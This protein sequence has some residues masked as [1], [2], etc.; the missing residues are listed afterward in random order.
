MSEDLT[1]ADVAA[2]LDRP[3]RTVRLWCKQGRFAGARSVTT[4]RGDYWLI[5]TAA[6][7]DFQA[8]ER[9]RPAKPKAEDEMKSKRAQKARKKA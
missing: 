9:G 5:P 4:P 7:K 1:T 6:L 8:P 3:E 2:R